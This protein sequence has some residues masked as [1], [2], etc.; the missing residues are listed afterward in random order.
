MAMNKRQF[1]Y[2]YDPESDELSIRVGEARPAIA[3]EV[4]NEFFVQLDPDT[5]EVVGFTVLAFSKRIAAKDGTANHVA[6]PVSL[7]GQLQLA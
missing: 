4:G 1:V 7:E 2:D 5:Q 6:L 3:R